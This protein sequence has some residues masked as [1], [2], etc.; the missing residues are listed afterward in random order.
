MTPPPP[1]ND[2]G[3]TRAEN[4]T[5]PDSARRR[6]ASVRTSLGIAFVAFVALTAALVFHIRTA[7]DGEV[8]GIYH[9]DRENYEAL[10]FDRWYSAGSLRITQ[11]PYDGQYFLAHA[12]DPLLIDA[13]DTDKGSR[14][15]FYR[16]RR[17]AWSW[18][19]WALAGGNADV[20]LWT[21]PLASLLSTAAA[22][23]ALA[24]LLSANGRPPAFALLYA[25]ALGTATSLMRS[26]ADLFATNLAVIGACAWSCA[27]IRSATLVF[28]AAALAKETTILLPFCLA[29][30]SLASAVRRAGS[31]G[32]ARAAGLGKSIR[33]LEWRGGLREPVWLLLVPAAMFSWWGYLIATGSSGSVRNG[34]IGIPFAGIVE[35]VSRRGAASLSEWTAFLATVFAVGVA[36]FDARRLLR[37]V[38]GFRLAAL[39]FAVLAIFTN[40][41]V[42][43]EMWAYGRVHMILPAL[44]LVLYAREGRA[45]D[46]TAAVMTAIAGIAAWAAFF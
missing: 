36:I 20:I 7:H 9:V 14:A 12:N 22:V 27:R 8:S 17:I 32:T 2:P 5:E 39:A 43:I 25:A 13:T 34:N 18:S 6:V 24:W 42:W 11:S 45:V 41:T 33:Q 21:L 35:Y 37:N 40:H 30:A 46:S 16:G 19:G 38:D 1:A 28:A 26:T 15:R 10:R 23:F 31:A 29:L 3:T 4:A 44:L